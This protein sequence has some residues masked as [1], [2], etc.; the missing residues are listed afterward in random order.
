MIWIWKGSRKKEAESKPSPSP[1]TSFFQTEE[2]SYLTIPSIP[3]STDSVLLPFSAVVKLFFF[4]GGG[5]GFSGCC[6]TSPSS[7]DI[8]NP[9]GQEWT[10][11]RRERARRR[12]WGY[13]WPSL[14]RWSSGG[15]KSSGWGWGEQL[16][17]RDRW[18]YKYPITCG[19][20]DGLLLCHSACILP[21]GRKSCR[22]RQEEKEGEYMTMYHR[23]KK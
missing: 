23:L 6:A 11:R 5:W 18:W 19:Y 15:W 10:G 2:F 13:T 7:W 12:P 17:G 14:R 21:L 16:L 8:I 1:F 20:S 9:P 22:A 3:Y 4:E